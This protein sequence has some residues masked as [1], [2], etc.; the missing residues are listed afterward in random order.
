[1]SHPNDSSIEIFHHRAWNDYSTKQRD[2]VD[3]LNEIIRIIKIPESYIAIAGVCGVWCVV[4]SVYVY[5]SN[6]SCGVT[7]S[8]SRR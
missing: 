2:P 5:W 8:L 3:L 1:M 7:Y 4:M 6:M